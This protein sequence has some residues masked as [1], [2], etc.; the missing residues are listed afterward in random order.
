MIY[1]SKAEALRLDPPSSSTS[2]TLGRLYCH[3]YP[4]RTRTVKQLADSLRCSQAYVRAKL[5][6]LIKLD[7]AEFKLVLDPKTGKKVQ[8]YTRKARRPQCKKLLKSA[9]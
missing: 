3:L 5:E 1:V 8:H 2:V 6:L 9:D 7:M 4:I